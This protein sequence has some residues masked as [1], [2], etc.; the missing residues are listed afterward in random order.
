[1]KLILVTLAAAFLSLAGA[2][3]DQ[4]ARP[5]IY[6]IA[7]VRFKTTDAQKSSDFYSKIIGLT[8]GHDGC[9]GPSAPC[10]VVNPYQYVEL[11]QTGAQERGSFLEEV[12]FTTG[13]LPKMRE[14]LSAR[15]VKT[16]DIA[17]GPNGL[18]FFEL[19]DPEHNRVAF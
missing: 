8:E 1:M 5:K 16:T 11:V 19:E 17:L 10:F 3:P 7:F 14:Y 12:G 4:P 2:S 15:G 18:R 13:D 6:G 9:K